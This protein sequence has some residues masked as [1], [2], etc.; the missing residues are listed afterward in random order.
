MQGFYT[1]AQDAS[2]RAEQSLQI[3]PSGNFYSCG[4]AFGDLVIQKLS[5]QSFWEAPAAHF[6]SIN[7]LIR[8]ASFFPKSSASWIV[9][10]FWIFLFP[11]FSVL[12]VHIK[13]SICGISLLAQDISLSAVWSLLSPWVFI[14]KKWAWIGKF[15]QVGFKYIDHIIKNY[16]QV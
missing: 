7:V 8:L 5:I 11:T 14:S 6:L 15:H 13:Y 1:R 3:I 4:K 16:L 9:V 10:V 2:R 12:P